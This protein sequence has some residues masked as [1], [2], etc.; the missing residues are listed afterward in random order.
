MFIHEL[1]VS[2]IEIILSSKYSLRAPSNRKNFDG[3]L[4]LVNMLD[5]EFF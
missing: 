3:A 2:Y 1:I 4:Y 5:E